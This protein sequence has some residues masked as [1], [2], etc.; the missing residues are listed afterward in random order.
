MDGHDLKGLKPKELMDAVNA[1]VDKHGVRTLE[2]LFSK[3]E[4]KLYCILDGP[5]EEAVKHHH[6]DIGLSCDFIT[7]V[8]HIKDDSLHK[9]DKLISI[10]E[11]ASRF[12]HDVR[13]PLNAVTNAV[14]IIQIKHSENVDDDLKRLLEIIHSNS[15]RIDS[16]ISGILN[17]LRTRPLSV[18]PISILKLLEVS[19]NSAVFSDLISFEFPTNDAIIDGDM[20]QLEIVL[21]NL[22]NNSIQAI[23][24]KNGQIVV[25]LT[26]NENDV[27]IRIRD[28][29][30][31]IPIES[32]DKIFDVLYTTKNQGTGLGLSSCKT[33]IEQHGGKIQVIPS[34]LGAIFEITLPKKQ[35]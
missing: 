22:F 15:K 28:S 11:I 6:H 19:K 16:Q 33:I 9:I 10:G 3:N 14:E 4:D 17:F 20:T 31:G 21:N 5:D 13:N 34:N 25:S 23:G 26:E 35:S 2:V 29:G 18:E 8:D 24:N 27:V 12:A 1:P 30:P 32:A 7:K